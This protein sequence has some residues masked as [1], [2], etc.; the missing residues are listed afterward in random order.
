MSSENLY[1]LICDLYNTCQDEETKQLLG[2]IRTIKTDDGE[3]VFLNKLSNNTEKTKIQYTDGYLQNIHEQDDID[4]IYKYEPYYD[5]DEDNPF[6]YDS[7]E[8][9]EEEKIYNEYNHYWIEG[10]DVYRVE[11]VEEDRMIMTC[12]YKNDNLH[13]HNNAYAE[14]IVNG[15]TIIVK[16]Y[17]DGKLHST[18]GPA[19]QFVDHDKN[20][21]EVKYYIEGQ[22]VS[23]QDFNY[24]VQEYKQNNPEAMDLIFENI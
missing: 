13:N 9:E 1:K 17:K 16:S 3:I 2:E 24:K 8:D 10:D 4:V 20:I 6:D 19:L 18:N 14:S 7:S 22:S 12:N 5:Y 21:T 15:N 11:I 23:E